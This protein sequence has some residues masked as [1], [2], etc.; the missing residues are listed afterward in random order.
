MEGFLRYEFG[1]LIF[2]GAYTWR[3]LFSEFYGI[4]FTD[5]TSTS[6]R[7][8]QNNSEQKLSFLL[9]K[10]GEEGPDEKIAKTVEHRLLQDL[11]YSKSYSREV[12]PA[13]H[14]SDVLR[15]QF[16]MSLVQIVDVVS[17][18]KYKKVNNF[19]R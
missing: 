2:G 8:Q 16:S 10:V 14:N 5:H 9:V 3:G 19:R 1:R 11:I 12:R 4:R 18:K 17:F 13:L 7:Q 15:V 6:K